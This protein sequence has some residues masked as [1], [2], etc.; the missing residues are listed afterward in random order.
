MFISL[1]V[2]NRNVTLACF[3][4]VF[5]VFVVFDEIV[6]RRRRALYCRHLF[7]SRILL[8]ETDENVSIPRCKYALLKIDYWLFTQQGGGITHRL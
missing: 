7:Q 4:L 1:N 5:F 8:A 3:E 2:F 6:A